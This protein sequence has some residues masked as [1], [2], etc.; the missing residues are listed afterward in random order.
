MT[1]LST[2]WSVV[3]PPTTLSSPSWR[4]VRIPWLQATRSMLAIG[5]CSMIIRSISSVMMSTSA[6]TIRPW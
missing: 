4:S 2:S 3:W 5:C 1:T 6:R